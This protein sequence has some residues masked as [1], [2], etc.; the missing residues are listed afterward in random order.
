[1]ENAAHWIKSRIGDDLGLTE[2]D[3]M[4]LYGISP[5]QLDRYLVGLAAD[6]EDA[7][8]RVLSDVNAASAN[9]RLITLSDDQIDQ[10]RRIVADYPFHPLSQLDAVLGHAWR[11]SSDDAQW[12]AFRIADLLGLDFP[13]SDV[14]RLRLNRLGLSY[15]PEFP[16]FDAAFRNRVADT[17]L[18]LS[19]LAGV[20]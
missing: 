16:E 15:E 7:V 10:A 5:V 20:L 3:L 4:R 1:M 14:L 6:P 11:L 8:Q 12:V 2:D 17:T 9:H 18:Y 13:S 19:E